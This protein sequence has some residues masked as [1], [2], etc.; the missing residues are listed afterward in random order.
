[1]EQWKGFQ[2]GNWS[3]E[4]NVRD[5]IINNITV[6]DKDDSFLAGPTDKTKRVL[7]IYEDMCLEEV[8]KHVIDIDNINAD[9]AIEN[10]YF[11]NIF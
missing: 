3:K 10:N 11:I 8:E 5:F 7:K 6:Y 2:L 4:I 1:M 9:T